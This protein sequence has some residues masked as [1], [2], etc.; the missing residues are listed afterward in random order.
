MKKTINIPALFLALLLTL[1]ICGTSAIA[2]SSWDVGED[3]I[4]SVLFHQ[5]YLEAADIKVNYKSDRNKMPEKIKSALEKEPVLVNFEKGGLFG[6]DHY[7]V[8]TKSSGYCYYGKIKSNKPDGFGVLTSGEVRLDDLSTIKNLIYAGNFKKG[9][10]DGYGASFQSVSRDYST[11]VS[12]FIES[13]RLEP[14]YETIAN[15]YLESCVTYDGGWKKGIESGKGNFFQLDD[16]LIL[17]SISQAEYWGGTVYPIVTVTDVK[18]SLAHG[19]TKRYA[20]GVLV[21]DG[22][23][24]NGYQNGKG[25]SY[26]LNGQKEYDGQW[27][28]GKYDGKGKLYDENGALVYNGKWKNGDY[29]S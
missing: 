21:F 25:T 18:K 20:Y 15:T 19:N 29:A 26:F 6:T 5:P 22:K 16:Y 8:T 3:D 27:K 23:T 1:N 24:K 4:L 10:Y 2:A 7:A 11:H 12:G 13:G 14:Q 28:D 17:N 9:F